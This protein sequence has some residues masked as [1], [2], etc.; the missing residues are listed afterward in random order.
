MTD[1]DLGLEKARTIVDIL[2]G[3][4]GEDIL[5]LDLIGECTFTDYFVLCSGPS[6]RTLKALAEEVRKEMK[7]RFD[8]IATVEGEAE[9]GWMLLDYGDVVVHLF[10]DA[11]RRYYALE[12]L[13]DS[14]KVLISL[15]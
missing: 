12:E 8:R 6:V 10:S 3:K 11:V 1:R 7:D 2:E 15:Q 14:G 13:W 4:K 9:S 5:L